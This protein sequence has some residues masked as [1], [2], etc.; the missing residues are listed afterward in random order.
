MV[1][2]K[3]QKM[4][5]MSITVP[6][7][8]SE[9]RTA[10]VYK[11]Y[12]KQWMLHTC[13]AVEVFYGGAV[14]GGKTF[15]FIWDAINRCLDRPG[16]K[17]LFLRETMAET[18][19]YRDKVDGWVG[20]LG[21]N[22]ATL[23]KNESRFTFPNY[24]GPNT[25][26]PS[27][28]I[29]GYCANDDDV[30]RYL[31]EE[32][33]AI[34][35]DECTTL[36]GR[37]MRDLRTRMRS[38]LQLEDGSEN[39]AVF[40]GAA[41]PRGVGFQDVKLRYVDPPDVEVEYV[42]YWDDDAA[43]N[44]E[45]GNGWVNFRDGRRGPA[46][47]NDFPLTL[48]WRPIDDDDEARE[49]NARRVALGVP[50][51]KPHTRC[52]IR[53]RLEDNPTLFTSTQ[54]EATLRELAGNDPKLYRALRDGRWDQFIGQVFN[55]FTPEIHVIPPI[56]VPRTWVKWRS[57]DWGYAAPSCVLWHTLNPYLNRVITYRE[58]YVTRKDDRELCDLIKFHSGDEHYYAT[59]ADPSMWA[60]LGIS[61][62][63][64]EHHPDLGRIVM[65]GK[66]IS[67]AEIF[68]GFGVQ[69][70][71]GNNDRMAGKQAIHRHLA[72]RPAVEATDVELPPDPGWQVTSNCQNLIRTLPSLPYDKHKQEDVD[73][74][75]DDHP[76]DSLRY[77]LLSR[78]IGE[79][80]EFSDSMTGA[81]ALLSSNYG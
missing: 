64:L 58:L 41:N 55:E 22:Q 70:E 31:S 6:T 40:R 62:E 11:P 7:E 1:P 8:H 36:Q 30:E 45:H 25:N 71:P 38:T 50:P 52:Y 72:L 63:L 18:L 57:M 67:R 13:P 28:L 23:N 19:S 27:M 69:L 54:Y 68:E 53:A 75:G 59:Y 80:I 51:V 29:L 43:A 74:N 4:G 5:A 24:V 15:C 44:H 12:P 60:N 46:P 78:G 14:G 79:Q 21:T 47:H 76:Y 49:L 33:D 65:Q 39:E 32:Y 48:V 10:F 3:V 77:A 73:T 2:E 81:Q 16:A 61:R 20:K 66:S 42:S 56:S 34:Y 37:W 9:S 26:L 35:I 17:V